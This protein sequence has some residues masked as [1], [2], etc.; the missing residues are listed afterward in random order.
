MG[1]RW[2]LKT[3]GVFLISKEVWKEDITEGR[4]KGPRAVTDAGSLSRNG[5]VKENKGVTA[6]TVYF[7]PKT[8]SSSSF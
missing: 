5:H 4:I 2:S 1:R 8:S 7:P 6:A 3:R